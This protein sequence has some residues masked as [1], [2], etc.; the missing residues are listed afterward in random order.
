[1]KYIKIITIKPEKGLLVYDLDAP[2]EIGHSYIHNLGKIESAK[3]TAG[4][5]KTNHQYQFVKYQKY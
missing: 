5:G 2:C 4:I 1:M 3:L